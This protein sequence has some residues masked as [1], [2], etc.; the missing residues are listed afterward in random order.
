MSGLTGKPEGAVERRTFRT[1]T[2]IMKSALADAGQ[3]PLVS[4]I[5]PPSRVEHCD[6]PDLAP[7]APSSSNAPRNARNPCACYSLELP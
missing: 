1:I 4:A 6:I 2:L 7:E 5:R 3:H